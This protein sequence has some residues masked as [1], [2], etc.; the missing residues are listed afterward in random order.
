MIL[1]MCRRVIAAPPDSGEQTMRIAPLFR[2]PLIVCA[3]SACHQDA[4]FRQE[5][6]AMGMVAHYFDKSASGGC[7]IKSGLYKDGVAIVGPVDMAFW[8][9][10]GKA[11]AVNEKARK[12]AP[13]LEP[14][15]AEIRYDSA[16]IDATESADPA[17]ERP[18]EADRALEEAK[19]LAN[20]G[21][22]EGALQKHLWYHE[23]A[24]SV[25]PA[26]YGVRLSFALSDW[27]D[28]GK[29]YP[30][31]IEALKAIR[32]RKTAQ[33]AAGKYDFDTFMDVVAINEQL[34]DASASVETF[35]QIAA[36][37]PGE[38]TGAY[39]VVEETLVNAK[40]FALARQYMGDPA[41]RLATATRNVVGSR[42]SGSRKGLSAEARKAIESNF[43]DTVIRIITVLKETGD[44]AGAAKIQAEALKTVDRP[45]IRNALP[46]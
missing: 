17:S 16:F 19:A 39:S 28:L 12:A 38:A 35:K 31:A 29:K 11:Y 21:D 36:S 33:L 6:E 1:L 42:G 44:T 3:L 22:Y 40:E 24:L 14:A 30:K 43:C 41:E 37:S 5:A 4:E 46:H 2:L 32:D 7:V 8:V 10:E 27:M 18:S 23:H 20:A 9:K 13:D 25:D 45:E 15:P 34:G 26:H